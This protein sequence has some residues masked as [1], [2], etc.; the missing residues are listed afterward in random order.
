MWT[1][2]A[3]FGGE[4]V[5]L[6]TLFLVLCLLSVC[7]EV[8]AD[9]QVS[10]SQS[11]SCELGAVG[12]INNHFAPSTGLYGLFLQDDGFEI[13]VSAWSN[14]LR[15][16]GGGG[17]GTMHRVAAR[18]WLGWEASAEYELYMHDGVWFLGLGPVLEVPVV[19]HRLNVFLVIPVGLEHSAHHDRF[20]WMANVGLTVAIWH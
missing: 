18:F 9:G 15:L 4:G 3:W 20:A 16:G 5:M 6:R 7:P 14:I 13:H 12:M 2:P 19:P 1:K 17:A 10:R 11:S 8:L